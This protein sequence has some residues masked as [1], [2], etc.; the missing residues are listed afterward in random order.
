MDDF[1]SLV[2]VADLAATLR[3]LPC[4]ES[5]EPEAAAARLFQDNLAPSQWTKLSTL[6]ESKRG[7]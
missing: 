5:L 3:D 4:C 6:C 2:D 1:V 7:A